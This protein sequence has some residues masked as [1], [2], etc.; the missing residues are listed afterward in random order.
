M[1][2]PLESPYSCRVSKS[3][4]GRGDWWVAKDCLKHL[5]EDHYG[6]ATYARVLAD[7]INDGASE[8]ARIA[9]LKMVDDGVSVPNP[10]A[11]AKESAR[12]LLYAAGKIRRIGRAPSLVGVVLEYVLHRKFAPFVWYR[13]AGSRHA[14]MEHIAFTVKR[15]YESDINACIVTLDSLCD[16]VW[17]IVF[18]REVIGKAYGS[19]GAMLKHP[20]LVAKY[21]RASRGFQSLHQL[22]LESV[23]AHPRT[24]SGVATR[25][26][27]HHDFYRISP[28]VRE[29]IEEV[30]DLTV[31]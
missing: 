11:G 4:R 22:R 15:H 28:Y 3:L 30:I 31:T 9:A 6:P 25:R 27:K 19:Y 1:V 29:A 13:F 8:P 21:A 7:T 10:I 14:G 18:T 20:A 2:S 17:E 24:K 26:L 12:L 16:A 5:R 23:T